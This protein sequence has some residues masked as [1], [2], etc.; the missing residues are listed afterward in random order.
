VNSRTKKILLVLGAMWGVPLV[1]M[2]AAGLWVKSLGMVSVH[3]ADRRDGTNIDLQVPGV[4]ASAGLMFLPDV[5]CAEMSDEMDGR[6]GSVVRA[7]ESQLKECPDAVFVQVES[8]DENVLIRKDGKHLVIDVD[9][10]DETVHLKVPFHLVSTVLSK[11]DGDGNMV[12]IRHR[13]HLRQRSEL[14]KRDVTRIVT[15]A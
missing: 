14:K 7:L 15:G 2:L 8:D 4:L 10:D 6:W 13:D 3:V 5:V 1:A 9:S 11:I 12:R